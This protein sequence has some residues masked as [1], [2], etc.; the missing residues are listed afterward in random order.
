MFEAH[1]KVDPEALAK[2]VKGLADLN[3]SKELYN[4]IAGVQA[5][6]DKVLKVQRQLEE[7]QSDLKQVVDLR[8]TALYGANWKAVEGE[9]Y[10]IVKSPTGAVYTLQPDSKPSKNFLKIETSVNTDVV[11]E[12]IAEHDG[13]LPKGIDMNPKRGASIRIAVKL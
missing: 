1:I 4:A 11:N 9:G 3:N 12:Y 5:E 7:I 10:K 6:L 2:T 8:G 13:K